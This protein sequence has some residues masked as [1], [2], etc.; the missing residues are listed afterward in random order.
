M[1]EKLI[2]EAKK[3]REKAY[4]PYSK[5]SVGAALLDAQ[6]NIYH[7]CNIENAAYSM[8]NC[9]E[10]TALFHAYATGSTEYKMMAVVADTDRPVSPCGA[11][12]QVMAELCHPEMKVILT[13]LD[14]D[15]LETTVRDLLPGAFIADDMSNV[16]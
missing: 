4:V 1:E 12:R 11:C 2:E 3:A 15:I 13:N 14:G 10:R 6:G 9:G 5:F 8:C 7:G 16:K